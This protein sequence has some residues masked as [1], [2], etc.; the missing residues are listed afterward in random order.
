MNSRLKQ[1]LWGTSQANHSRRT[2]G[3]T[4]NSAWRR[5]DVSKLLLLPAVHQKPD[6]ALSFAGV[7]ESLQYVM[8]CWHTSAHLRTQICQHILPRTW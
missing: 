6:T 1:I 5:E 4:S 7:W 8:A 2:I 3:P